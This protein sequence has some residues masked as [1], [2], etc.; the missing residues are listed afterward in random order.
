[1]TTPDNRVVLTI[2][3]AAERLGIGRTT[4]YTLIK[5]GQIRTVT[6]GR[7]R[8]VPAFCLDEYVRNLL[9]DSTMFKNAA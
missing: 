7:L 8:R 4:M 5:T 3:Q 6:I 2:E 1:M 9:A